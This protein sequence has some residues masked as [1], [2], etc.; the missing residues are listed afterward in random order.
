M[1]KFLRVFL[2]VV[3]VILLITVVILITQNGDHPL[4][5]N[6]VE[7]KGTQGAKI[8]VKPSEGEE[9]YLDNVPATVDVPVGATVILKHNGK[10]K[11]FS[12]E[13][14]K[15][16]REIRYDFPPR[17]DRVRISADPD[18]QIFIKRSE[19]AREEFIDDVPATVNI[20]IGATIILRY[21]NEEKRFLYE[22]ETDEERTQTVFYDF[23]K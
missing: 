6:R 16:K 3:A 20:P 11:Q 23:S 9:R 10:E 17:V 5:F 4:P 22:E 7:I 19:T 13:D 12:S 1:N 8:Y 14:L 18:A 2:P 15:E 21:K